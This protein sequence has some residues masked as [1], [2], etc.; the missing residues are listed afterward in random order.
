MSEF[1]GTTGDGIGWHV[2]APSAKFFQGEL[3]VCCMCGAKE[4][5]RPDVEN[6]WRCIECDGRPYYVCPKHLPPDGSPAWKFKKAYRR[7][8]QFVLAHFRRTHAR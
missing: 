8:L 2:D 1:L 5:S 4:Q 6:G 7:I 3:M